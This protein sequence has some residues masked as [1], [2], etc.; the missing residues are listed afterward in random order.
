MKGINEVKKDLRELKNQMHALKGLE[1]LTKTHE[2]RV[3]LLSRLPK[4]ERVCALIENEEQLI[5]RIDASGAFERAQE[6]ELFYIDAINK[7]S[8]TDKSIIVDTFLNGLPYW[9][10]GAELGFS[11]ETIRKRVVRAISQIAKMV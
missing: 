11:E 7:L 10:I 9:K 2:M 6:L 8:P 3:K 5:Q 1:T 4:S